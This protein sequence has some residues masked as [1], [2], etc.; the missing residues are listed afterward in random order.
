LTGALDDNQRQRLMQ[1]A[2]QCPVHQTLTSEI[3]IST[4]LR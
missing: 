4:S 3:D 1:I 2:N